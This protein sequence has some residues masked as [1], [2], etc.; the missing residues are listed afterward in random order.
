M[1]NEQR[2]LIQTYLQKYLELKFPNIKI[3]NK[4]VWECP[5]SSEHSNQ[6]NKPSCKIYPALGYKLKCF[7]ESHGEIGDIFD[8]VKKCEPS[9]SKLSD[10]DI[11]EYLINLLDIQTNDEV[12]E[13]LA[14]YAN[15][16]F[17]LIPLQPKSKNPIEGQSWFKT[18]SDSLIQW[19]EWYNAHLNL[20]L[21]LGKDSG[22]VA[23]D[24]DSDETFEKVKGL[25][26]EG[27]VHKTKRGAHY[28]F[29]NEECFDDIKH[30]NFRNKGYDMELRAN[31]AYIVVAPSSVEG[32]KREW[33]GRKITKMPKELKDFVFSLIDKQPEKESEEAEKLEDTKLSGDLKGL[34]GRC[35]QTFIQ[36]GGV[37]SKTMPLKYVETSLLNF[38][39]LLDQ[40]M[41]YQDV[42]RMMYQI[43]KYRNYDKQELMEEVFNHLKIVEQSTSRDLQASLHHEK[44]DIEEVLQFLIEEGKVIKYKN[45]YKPTNVVDWEEDFMSVSTPLSFN[46]PYFDNYARFSN[47][48]MIILGAKS[49]QGKTHFS[50][51][52]I[53][54]FVEQGIQPYL[55]CTEAES[56]F[57][58]ISATLGLKVGD[59]KYKLVRDPSNIELEDNS[60][61]IIDWLKAP[62]SDYAKMESIYERLN[63]QLAK[64]K[65]LLIILA[66]LKTE[67]G[68]FYAEDMTRHYASFLA[69]YFWS[70]IK[71]AKGNV[72]D[73]DSNNTYFKTEKIRDSKNGKQYI[74]IP[75]YFNPDTKTLELRKN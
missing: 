51:N 34:D 7:N 58:I 71:D 14:V 37:L 73:W 25:L 61:T 42:K 72:Y 52:I 53:K 65:G 10:E 45:L 17:K 48:S 68:Q 2:K 22:V 15:S 60:V 23:I 6:D 74:N 38:N 49:G 13:T 30:I 3:N 40:P 54:K 20:G 5:F 64:H 31:N 27:A 4:N 46:V 8:V 69:K 50:C 62:E 35:N 56:K 26:G 44:K 47:G 28:I 63:E 75:T 67:S 16:G 11:A 21:V 36:L 33:N 43:K 12:Q 32:E 19:Q 9:M 57:G 70:P 1:K 59:Y 41:Q 55:L 24:I 66:Q 29:L 39:K 18:M